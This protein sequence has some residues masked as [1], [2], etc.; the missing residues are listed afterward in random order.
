MVQ[1]D[2]RPRSFHMLQVWPKKKDFVL[3]SDLGPEFRPESLTHNLLLPHDAATLT[4]FCNFSQE[5]CEI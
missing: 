2:P 5:L 3:V 4:D 1:F